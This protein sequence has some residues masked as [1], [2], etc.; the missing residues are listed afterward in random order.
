MCN[1]T[2]TFYD[3]MDDSRSKEILTRRLWDFKIEEQKIT[4]TFTLPSGGQFVAYTGRFSF[5]LDIAAQRKSF[6]VDEY[7]DGLKRE[8]DSIPSTY[9]ELLEDAEAIQEELNELDWE[10]EVVKESDTWKTIGNI[11]NL[12]IKYNVDNDNYY[13]FHSEVQYN[14]YGTLRS[15]IEDIPQYYMGLI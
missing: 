3:F 11:G 10:L 6:D 12:I 2:N 9:K 13:I 15:L 7:I 4:L 5:L 1:I 14:H 8:Q